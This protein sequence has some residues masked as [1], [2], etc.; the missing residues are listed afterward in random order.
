MIEQCKVQKFKLK[1]FAALDEVYKRINRRM[2]EILLKDSKNI[3]PK[4]KGVKIEFKKDGETKKVSEYDVELSDF[5]AEAISG[6]DLITIIKCGTNGCDI[7][8]LD[9][10]EGLKLFKEIVT[11]EKNKDFFLKSYEA[12][13]IAINPR[14][15]SSSDSGTSSSAS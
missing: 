6:E 14:S 5:M 8:K 15:A 4:K 7:D 1:D 10:D 3:D 2:N 11:S 12:K 13:M 9:W